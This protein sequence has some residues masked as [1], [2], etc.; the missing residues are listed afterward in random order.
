MSVESAVKDGE[1]RRL[2]KNARQPGAVRSLVRPERHEVHDL[3]VPAARGEQLAVEATLRQRTQD[4]VE[5]RGHLSGGC[6]HQGH[7]IIFG[8]GN[9]MTGD[10]WRVVARNAPA[11]LTQ[12]GTKRPRNA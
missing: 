11:A 2:I 8:L 4:A 7:E 1:P 6:A 12:E 10:A 5:V 9:P 3:H